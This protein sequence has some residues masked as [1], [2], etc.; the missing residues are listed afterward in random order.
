MLGKKNLP[1]KNLKVFN[2]PLP[3]CQQGLRARAQADTHELL[4]AAALASSYRTLEWPNN[5]FLLSIRYRQHDIRYENVA[6]SFAFHEIH[7]K[8][9][10]AYRATAQS[11]S[12]IPSLVRNGQR[13]PRKARSGAIIANSILKN[14]FYT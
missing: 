2:S 4:A 14:H 11:S 1:R 3:L 5:D 13:P 12:E 7:E 6:T 9:F 8:R 10:S